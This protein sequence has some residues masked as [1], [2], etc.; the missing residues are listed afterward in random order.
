MF[1]ARKQQEQ[2]GA[3]RAEVGSLQGRLAADINNLNAGD[4]AVS[5]QAL[6]DAAE[7][8]NSA[9]SLLDTAKSAGELQVAMRVVVEGLTAT[10]IV[11]ERQGLPLG[12]DLP[13]PANT[14]PEPTAVLHDGE[15]HIAYPDYHPDRPHFFGGGPVGSTQAPAGY[16]KTP[17]WKKA[18]AIGVAVVAGEMLGDVLGDVLNGGF[19]GGGYG[20]GMGGGMGG[21]Y[22]NDGGD[23]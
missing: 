6:V 3:L 22:D 2:L 11:R 16:Y 8:F 19:N 1:G 10:R 21:G 20:A 18:A 15:E 14:V 17:F 12:A 13:E 7:R 5:R 9:G 23:W 4:D